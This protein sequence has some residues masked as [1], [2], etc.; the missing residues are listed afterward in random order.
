MHEYTEPFKKKLFSLQI[1]LKIYSILNDINFCFARKV[2]QHLKKG[3]KRFEI[4][5]F[6]GNTRDLELHGRL[7]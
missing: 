2:R 3:Q 4:G 1:C 5:G 6:V 7:I